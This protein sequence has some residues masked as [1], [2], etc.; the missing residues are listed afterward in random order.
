MKFSSDGLVAA[1]AVAMS[2]PDGGTHVELIQAASTA[3]G[4]RGLAEAVVR[5]AA[6]APVAVDGRSGAQA[7]VDRVEG[8]VPPGS[9]SLVST[10]DATAACSELLDEVR[11][12][13]LTWYR[14]GGQSCDDRLSCSALTSGRRPMGSRGGWGFG[15]EDPA[16]VEAAA[17]ALWQARKSCTGQDMEVYF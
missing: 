2:R 3:Q 17:L 12:H 16:P 11:E 5:A 7:L 13:T 14:P 15:G 4:T 9:V 1:M 8:S 10:A 6:V